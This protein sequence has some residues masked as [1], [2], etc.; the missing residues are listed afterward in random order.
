MY[1]LVRVTSGSVPVCTRPVDHFAG[2]GADDMGGSS[3]ETYKKIKILIQQTIVYHE[4]PVK[5]CRPMIGVRLSVRIPLTTAV[6]IPHV[7]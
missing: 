6:C 7:R 4:T 2:P 3:C 5:C 1:V